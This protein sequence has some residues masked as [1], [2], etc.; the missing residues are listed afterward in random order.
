[1]LLIHFTSNLQFRKKYSINIATLVTEK[2]THFIQLFSAQNYFSNMYNIRTHKSQLCT[3]VTNP[4]RI[5]EHSFII[6]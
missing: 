4:K 1:M 3:K 6:S 2:I 5:S